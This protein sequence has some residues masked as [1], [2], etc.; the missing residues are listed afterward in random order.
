MKTA[1]IKFVTGIL[2]LSFPGCSPV[3]FYSD[4]GLKKSTGF[5]YYTSK[6]YLQVERDPVS[7]NIVKMTVLY[8][9]DLENPAYIAIKDGLG[10]RKLDIKLT[11]GKITTLGMDTDPLIAETVTAL[12]NTVSK[13]SASVADLS[14]VKGVP[15][16][17][18]NP[19]VTELYDIIITNGTTS[20]KRIEVK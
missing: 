8:L 14:T 7:S 3:R 10:S 11:E 9:P 16:S 2:I 15:P 1:L 4:S 19:T 13:I 20:L 5:K 12:G 17:A 6:P 18:G